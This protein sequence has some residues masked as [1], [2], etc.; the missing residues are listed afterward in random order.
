MAHHAVVSAWRERERALRARGHDIELLSARKWDEGGRTVALEAGDDTFVEGVTTFGTHPNGFLFAPRPLWRALGEEVDLI[1]L[2]EEPFA[3]ATAQILLFRRLRGNRAPYLLYSAQNIEKRY[4]V[5]IRWFERWALRGAAGVYVCN[6][7]AG[8]ILVRKG[9]RG[10]VPLIPLGVDLAQFSP[11]PKDA[12]SSAAV[13][14]YIGRLEPHKGVDHLLRAIAGRPDWRVEITGDGPERES[15]RALVAELGIADRV[16]FLGFASGGELAERYRRLDVIAIPSVPT[17]RWLEQFCRVAVEAM[18]SGVPI[19]ASRSG[20]IPDVVGD[21]G[22]LVEPGRSAPLAEALDAAL[23]PDEWSRL[24]TRGLERA[25][26]FTWE[27]VAEQQDELYRAVAPVNDGGAARR[28][29]VV[30]V[31]Y[32][33]PALLDGALER[34][35]SDFPV[36][37]VDNSSSADVRGIAERVG[38]HYVDPGRNLGFGAAVNRALDSLAERGLAGDD[39]LLLNPD[40]RVDPSDVDAMHERL[41]A[42]ART[43]AVGATQTDPGT[44]GPARVWWPFPHPA[45]TWLEAVGLGR[46]NRA[47]GFAIG[48]LL[49]L[50]AE[51][52]AQIG[53]FDERFFLYAEEVD[54]QKRAID[55][56]WTIAVEPTSATHI[57]AATEGDSDRR[58]A[59][60]HASGEKYVRKHF[61]PLGWQVHRGGVIVGAGIRAV[62]LP[63]GRREEAARRLRRYVRG[64]VAALS[65]E[66]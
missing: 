27:R 3:I 1:D 45:R 37:I 58:E 15:L 33:D 20:A 14:G 40:A 19:V 60:F 21:A 29:Q 49:L 8:E 36:T 25:H 34:L 4:P 18:A 26:E 61:G 57:G 52:L 47:H 24:R 39:V 65:S 43:A 23:Q 11:A 17:P 62:V 16:S 42:T 10:E 51:A 30:A 55:G 13:V 38:A 28:P 6:R 32:G 53:R 54:W 9:L 2:H 50:R 35:G 66:E 22:I 41:H 31:A 12:V 46:L 59:L 5:P 56:G 64:P 7:E 63:R 48:S 44:G